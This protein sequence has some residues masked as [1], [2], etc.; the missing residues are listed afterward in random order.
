MTIRDVALEAGVSVATVSQALS[1][2]GRVAAGTRARV[3]SAADRV[4]YVASSAARNLRLGRSGAV[5]LYVPERGFGFEYYTQLARG[6]AEEALGHGLALTLVPGLAG[7]EGFG[8]LQ[9]DGLLVSDPATDDPAVEALRDLGVPTV[10][11]ERDLADPEAAV[12]VVRCDHVAAMTGLLDH[13]A[14]RGARRVAVVAPDGTT[15]FGQDVAPAPDRDD[16]T[17][18]VLP[19]PLAYTTGDLA[20]VMDSVVGWRP[21][22]VLTVADGAALHALQHLHRAGLSVPGDVLLASYVDGPT[23]SLTTPAVTAVDI[24]PRETGAL[25]VRALVAALDRTAGRQADIRVPTRLVPRASTSRDPA[26][27]S[28]VTPAR[29]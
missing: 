8:R 3:R 1:G 4:G 29:T 11:V 27:E 12:A 18:R 26:G 6:A 5:G 10:T 17:V 23:L 13:L 25:G 24:R 22:A 15:S 7:V 14:G 16:L 2:N 21:D 19:V 20:A 9:L 28:R